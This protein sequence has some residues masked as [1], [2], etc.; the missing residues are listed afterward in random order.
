MEIRRCLFRIIR[1][2][3]R[4][5]HRFSSADQWLPAAANETAQILISHE[6]LHENEAQ[7]LTASAGEILDEM[8]LR[9]IDPSKFSIRDLGLLAQRNASLQ[10]MNMHRSK[11][12]EFDAVALV[13][14]NERAIPS[15]YDRTAEDIREKRRLFYVAIT[16]AKRFLMYVVP[17]G[18]RPSRF[19]TE[20][21]DQLEQ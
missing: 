7:T 10:L 3:D 15:K 9:K 21:Y 20:I 1:S 19:L 5:M 14:I 17:T 8:A 12:K 2:A 13:G 4:L 11:G 16:R 6:L 18:N